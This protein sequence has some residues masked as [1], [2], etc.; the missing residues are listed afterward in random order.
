ME[1]RTK[2]PSS[3]K[4]FMKNLT[5]NLIKNLTKILFVCDEHNIKNSSSVVSISQTKLHRIGSYLDNASFCVTGPI[6]RL[7]ISLVWDG[8]F[9]NPVDH[10]AADQYGLDR[11]WTCDIDESDGQLDRAGCDLGTIDDPRIEDIRTL[12]AGRRW[13][14]G[15]AVKWNEFRIAHAFLLLAGFKSNPTKI[16]GIEQ[17]IKFVFKTTKNTFEHCSVI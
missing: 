1:N 17:S 7:S 15:D 9:W 3:R 12:G 6:W 8:K 13:T 14:S 16:D 11:N 10:N 4:F 5:K 2:I